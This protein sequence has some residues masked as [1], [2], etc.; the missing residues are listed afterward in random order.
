MTRKLKLAIDRVSALPNDEQDAIASIIL[1]EIEDDARWRAAFAK[2]QE[3]L[4]RLADEA[5]AEIAADDVLPYD[6]ASKPE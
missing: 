1:E 5:R 3:A 4:V 6:P 2:S